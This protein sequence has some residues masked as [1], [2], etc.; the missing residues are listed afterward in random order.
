MILWRILEELRV[1]KFMIRFSSFPSG[2]VALGVYDSEKQM[3]QHLYEA[4]CISDLELQVKKD[5]G[6]LIITTTPQ[7]PSPLSFPPIPGF[8]KP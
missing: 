4:N 3:Q 6:H 8:P 5:W 2:T 7:L 1:K